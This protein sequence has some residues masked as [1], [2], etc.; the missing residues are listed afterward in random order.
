MNIYITGA[1]GQ[2]GQ[3]LSRVFPEG[4]FLSRSEVDLSSKEDILKYFENKA[5]DLIINCA[6]YTQVDNAESDKDLAFFINGEVPAILGKI[7]KKIVHISTDYVFEGVNF[8]PYLEN[9]VTNPI[10]VYG[11]SKL[12]GELKLLESNSDAVIIRTSWVYSEFGKNFVKTILRMIQE[13]DEINIISDQVGTPT[14]AK[15]LAELIYKNAILNWKF[16]SGIYHFSSEGVASWY[17][18]A[19]AI[20]KAKKSK[21]KIHPILS[22]NYQTKARRP[23]YSVLDKNKIKKELKIEIPHWEAQLEEVLKSF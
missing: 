20:A 23:Y 7:A 1:Q 9:D 21:C 22:E 4:I 11:A 16:S 15:E 6:A 14:S 18:F 12:A 19:C 8:R 5:V 3:E 17:D 10:N 13:K 2:L